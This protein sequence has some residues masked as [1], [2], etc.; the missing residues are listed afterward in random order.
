MEFSD[1]ISDVGALGAA[2]D[3]SHHKFHGVAKPAYLVF[4]TNR[5]DSPIEDPIMLAH[6]E[7]AY[8]MRRRDERS[9]VRIDQ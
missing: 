3:N 9:R 6:T 7:S 5:I 1:G 8:S 4:E 2:E